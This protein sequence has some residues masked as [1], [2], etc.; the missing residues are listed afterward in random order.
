MWFRQLEFVTSTQAPA[1]FLHDVIISN[2]HNCWPIRICILF[3]S[4]FVQ[5][6]QNVCHFS[7]IPVD[8]K[9]LSQFCCTVSSWSQLYSHPKFHYLYLSTA[10]NTSLHRWG[11]LGSVRSVKKWKA[12]SPLKGPDAFQLSWLMLVEMWAQYYEIFQ[13]FKRNQEAGYLHSNIS[14]CQFWQLITGC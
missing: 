8:P 14:V 11:I 5:F 3:R 6:N 12:C 7:N 9:F 2:S 4:H 10:I 1:N 13:L